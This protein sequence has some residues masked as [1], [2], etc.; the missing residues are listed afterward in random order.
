VLLSALSPPTPKVRIA[1][2]VTYNVLKDVAVPQLLIVSRAPTFGTMVFVK[3]HALLD[4]DLTPMAFAALA[5][6]NALVDA[7]G[8]PHLT[9]SPVPTSVWAPLALPLAL[10][11]TTLLA[12][13]ASPVVPNVPLAAE[14]PLR[15]SVLIISARTTFSL[16]VHVFRPVQ[17]SLFLRLRLLDT[18]LSPLSLVSASPA[19]LRVGKMRVVCLC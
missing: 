10:Q 15:L 8:P 4:L 6:L 2:I 1:S 11:S 5:T 19:M 7:L 17:R 3:I 9:V 14:V 13:H 12:Q 16:M 18:T